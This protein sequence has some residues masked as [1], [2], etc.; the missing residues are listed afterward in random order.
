MKG[1]EISS[2]IFYQHVNS[3]CL[4][5]HQFSAS[6]NFD[7]NG[8]QINPNAKFEL[9]NGVTYIEASMVDTIIGADVK[10]N[11]ENIIIL[12]NDDQLNLNVNRNNAVLNSQDFSLPAAPTLKMV[13][14]C[15]L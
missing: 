8:A 9:V 5:A 6:V 13:Q 15:C 3:F 7:V 2:H 12:H 4:H 14:L 1:F 11:G 10:V